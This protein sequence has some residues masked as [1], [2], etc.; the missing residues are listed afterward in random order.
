ML[1]GDVIAALRDEAVAR[2]TLVGLDDLALMLRVEAAAAAC[3]LGP[4]EFA[5][6]AVALFS[7]DASDE[8][9]VSLIGAMGKTD[10]PGR[11]CLKR[12]LEFA[13]RPQPAGH[14]QACGCGEAAHA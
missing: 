2:E 5:A 13:L 4:G 6:D 12:M 7:S 1:L 11:V 10:D 3:D 9:W 8:D 14:G